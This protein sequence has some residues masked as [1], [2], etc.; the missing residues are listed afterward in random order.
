MGPQLQP[1]FYKPNLTDNVAGP[2][3]NHPL[4]IPS[5]GSETPSV[6]FTSEFDDS[7]FYEDIQ[8]DQ[9]GRE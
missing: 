4:I 6:H 2:P 5:R 9:D 8:V 7:E 1:V 3:V